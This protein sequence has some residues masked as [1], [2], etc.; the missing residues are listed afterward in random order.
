MLHVAVALASLLTTAHP[1]RVVL[2]PGHGGDQDGAIGPK[3]LV[4]KNLSLELC[5]RLEAELEATL[6]AQVMLTRSND[7]DVKLPDR[8]TAANTVNPD[9]FVSIH[10]N[11]MPTARLREKIQGV[12]TFFN[13]ASASDEEARAIADRENAEGP[14][15]HAPKNTGTLAFVLADLERTETHGDSSRLAYAIHQ[16]IVKGTGATDRG[17]QQ[18]PFYVLTGVDAPA[19]LVEVGFISHPDEAK[20]LSDPKYQAR[21]AHSIASGIAQF[22]KEIEQRDRLE[23]ARPSRP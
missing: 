7:E 12:E 20:R 18:A 15:Q 21:L 16:S 19:V 4:E 2:D 10:A 3:G 17:V 9:L 1:L 14:R 8:V 5:K 22:A 13:S 6:H 11:S 23:A